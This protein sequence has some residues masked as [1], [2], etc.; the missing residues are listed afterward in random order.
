MILVYQKWSNS[1]KL[2]WSHGWKTYSFNVEIKTK[3]C[4]KTISCV[5]LHIHAHSHIF[6]GGIK[7][8]LIFPFAGTL[9][10]QL[11][12]KKGLLQAQTKSF[13]PFG[14]SFHWSQSCHVTFDLKRYFSGVKNIVSCLRTTACNRG[15]NRT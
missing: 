1:T 15:L 2:L 5:S 7:A 13:N 8:V 3:Q 9:S 11:W 14:A 4:L 10:L 6:F 12:G